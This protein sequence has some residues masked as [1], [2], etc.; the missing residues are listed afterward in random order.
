M[1]DISG[2]HTSASTEQN[3]TM[4]SHRKVKFDVISGRNQKSF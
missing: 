2:V 1:S 4:M 3:I